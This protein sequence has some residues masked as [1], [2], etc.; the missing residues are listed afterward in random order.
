MSQMKGRDSKRSNRINSY[1]FEWESTAKCHHLP[2]W[3]TLPSPSGEA[4]GQVFCVFCRGFLWL[5]ARDGHDIFCPQNSAIQADSIIP[6][7]F[8][9]GCT[10]LW[11]TE[12]F[13]WWIPS[14]TFTFLWF[15]EYY[16]WSW[17]IYLIFGI[18]WV[19]TKKG[20]HNWQF[21]QHF[22][23]SLISLNSKDKSNLQP[24]KQNHESRIRQH[25]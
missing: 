4:I 1:I 17:W 12:R 7:H 20:R 15:I 19:M 24:P 13:W 22:G 10:A 25:R 2:G 8:V 6:Y 16:D 14:G 11:R 3:E 21:W 9:S 23:R 18:W 5:T